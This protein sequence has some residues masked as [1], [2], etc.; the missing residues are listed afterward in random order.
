MN[1]L[2]ECAP[3]FRTELERI[4]Q[5]VNQ[6]LATIWQRWQRY[7][8]ACDAAGMSAVMEEFVQREGGAR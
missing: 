2:A 4:A 6:P 5:R 8:S 1:D 7:E 3:A